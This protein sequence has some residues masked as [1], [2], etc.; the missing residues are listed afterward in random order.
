M[1]L[2]LTNIGKIENANIEFNGIT[3]IAGENNTGKSTVGKML[4]CVFHSFYKIEEQVIK[5][6]VRTIAR[7]LANYYHETANRFTRSFDFRRLA[8]NIVNQK[9]LFLDEKNLLIKEIQDFY[10]NNDAHFQRYI[11]QESLEGLLNQADW[12]KLII[13]RKSLFAK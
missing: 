5:E 3:V 11:K 13:H 8:E 1:N 10:L 12:F 6:R 4:Y 7:V 2:E 9:D